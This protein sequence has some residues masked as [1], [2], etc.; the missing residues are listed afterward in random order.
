MKWKAENSTSR[1]MSQRGKKEV[2][3]EKKENKTTR[4]KNIKLGGGDRAV[5]KKIERTEKNEFR[6][7][8]TRAL[9]Q[10][11]EVWGCKRGKRRAIKTIT[12]E[13]GGG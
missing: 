2:S 8:F 3:E 6:R 4:P 1:A 9:R 5:G 11:E 13:V 10:G 12:K 7:L